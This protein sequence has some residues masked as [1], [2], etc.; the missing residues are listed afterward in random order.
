MPEKPSLHDRLGNRTGR[1]ALGCLAFLF[2]L[3]LCVFG[4]FGAVRGEFVFTRGS[5]GTVYE[6]IAAYA[7]AAS[8]VIAG[9]LLMRYGANPWRREDRELDS[10]D[11]WRLRPPE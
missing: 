10:N 6:G 9:V 8:L 2:G 11:E 7:V 5:L 4:I 1:E 3:G